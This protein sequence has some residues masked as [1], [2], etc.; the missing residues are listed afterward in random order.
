MN[1]CRSP[2][3]ARYGHMADVM[4]L[5]WLLLHVPVEYQLELFDQFPEARLVW[6]A[7]RTRPERF[8]YCAVQ[9]VIGGH[10]GTAYRWLAALREAGLI[11][12]NLPRTDVG[13]KP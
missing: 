6:R 13:S 3:T 1:V 2:A 4:R 5:H 12:R 7:M 10:K 9:Q 8:T 11:G